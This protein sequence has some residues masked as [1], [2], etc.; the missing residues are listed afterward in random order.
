M[1]STYYDYRSANAVFRLMAS[2]LTIATKCSTLCYHDNRKETK[3]VQTKGE[4]SL[5]AS[6]SHRGRVSLA[7]QPLLLIAKWDLVQPL[8]EFCSGDVVMAVV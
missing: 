8:Y 4:K 1:L 3:E 2:Q 5:G 6:P 7:S